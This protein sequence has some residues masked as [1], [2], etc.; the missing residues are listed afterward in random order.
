[1]APKYHNVHCRLFKS[2][3]KHSNDNAL[4]IVS[5]FKHKSLQLRIHYSG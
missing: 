2:K 4:P 1:M 5:N 3:F